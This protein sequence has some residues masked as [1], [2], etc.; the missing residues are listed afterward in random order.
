MDSG[1]DYGLNYGL[2]FGVN[3]GLDF[4]LDSIMYGTFQAVIDCFQSC[5]KDSSAYMVVFK[6]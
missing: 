5:A 4:G 6:T 3:F 1:L 2:D